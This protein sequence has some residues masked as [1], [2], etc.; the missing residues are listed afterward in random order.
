VTIERGV[1]YLVT[2]VYDGNRNPVKLYVNGTDVTDRTANTSG[3]VIA[4]TV[5]QFNIGKMPYGTRRFPG[6][7]RNVRIWLG[8][9][10]TASQIAADYTNTPLAGSAADDSDFSWPLNE[11]AVGSVTT[12]NGSVGLTMTNV[13]NDDFVSCCVNNR[14]SGKALIHRP[15][16]M[17][18]S[19][20]DSESVILVQADGYSGSDLRFRVLGPEGVSG[21]E[22]QVW[23]HVNET[24]IGSGGIS[25]GVLM[26]EDLGDPAVGTYF[27]VPVKRNTSVAGGGRY[28]DDDT[29]TGYDGTDTDAG[30]RTEYNTIMPLPPVTAMS[31]PFTLSG[32]LI[33]TTQY[34]LSKKYVILGYDAVEKGKLITGT[35]SSIS[36]K[37][38]KAAGDYALKSDV[39]L[40]RIEVRT[41]DDVLIT[42]IRNQDGWN[43]DTDMGDTTLPVELSSFAANVITGG[44]RVQWISQSES[45]LLG[46]YVYRS[47][48]Q[49]VIDAIQVSPL[50]EATNSSQSQIYVFTDGET[51]ASHT[52][53]Y[54]LMAMD[55]NGSYSYYGPV[56]VTL[57]DS[58]YIPAVP[59]RTGLDKLYPNP[60][61]PQINISYGLK[62]NAP[63]K[64]SIYNVKGQKVLSR[65]TGVLEKGYHQ[66]IWDASQET[67]GIYFVVF[68]S[69]KHKELRKITLSK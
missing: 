33:G 30:T 29:E 44:V 68:E 41:Q 6:N 24:W 11:T 9:A 18:L 15:A 52:Y 34:P 21:N 32:G 4:Q 31:S 17:D 63:V 64:L 67:S 5:S 56:K 50:I 49:A 45:N 46:Y 40:Y 27:W 47:E 19:S 26:D 60:F 65:E 1:W 42:D 14:A 36:A 59:L 51:Q 58:D 53:F 25:T 16:R 61:N 37:G 23:D 2:G 69:G 12:G 66:Y 62:E 43:T 13:T 28:V 10:R 57:S 55:F 39:P 7:V 35:S 54:W 20:A 22:M 3:A 38:S 48:T 8:E